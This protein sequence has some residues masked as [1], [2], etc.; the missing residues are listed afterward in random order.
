[1]IISTPFALRVYMNQRDVTPWATS[2]DIEQP[3]A[4]LYRQWSVTFAGWS[5]VESGASWDIFGSYDPETTPRA[6]CLIRAGVVP[7]D[8]ERT[9][10]LGSGEMVTTT[11]SG[12]DRVWLMQRRAPRDTLVLVPGRRGAGA[13]A[14]AA[15]EA[16]GQPVGR[17]RTVTGVDTLHHAV[18]ELARRAGVN[19]HLATLNYPWQATVVDP[20][21]SYWEAILELLRPLGAEVWYRRS[22]NLLVIVD[23]LAP[24]YG[25]G[26]TINLPPQL[27]KSVNGWPVRQRRVRRLLTRIRACH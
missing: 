21:Q 8:R 11:V 18:R 9:V 1:M 2:I 10:G 17:Y 19:V 23:P 14:A 22:G 12:Y 13:G 20:A 6:E 26:T 5:A 7:E 24:R 3:P 16:F 15:I 4:C 27:V 25:L